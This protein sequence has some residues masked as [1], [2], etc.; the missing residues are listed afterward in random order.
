[1][2]LKTFSIP[3]ILGIWVEKKVFQ[4]TDVIVLDFFMPSMTGVEAAQILKRVSNV[5]APGR[6]SSAESKMCHLARKLLAP[7]RTIPEIL[8]FLSP[9][10]SRP[11]D[12]LLCPLVK[13]QIS[14]RLGKSPQADADH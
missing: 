1:M 12:Y 2:N 9:L 4:Q 8:I 7:Y 10:K 5:C 3:E 14:R 6:A 11:L 13:A